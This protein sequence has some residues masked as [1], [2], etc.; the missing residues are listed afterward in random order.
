MNK[1]HIMESWSGWR[2]VERIFDL[3]CLGRT[4][5]VTRRTEEAEEK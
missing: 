4:R 2:G 3:R 1:A 5:T